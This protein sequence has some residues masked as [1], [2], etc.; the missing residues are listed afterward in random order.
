MMSD[1]KPGTWA[2]VKVE[3]TDSDKAFIKALISFGFED[4]EFRANAQL[5]VKLGVGV[6]RWFM[7]RRYQIKKL[8]AVLSENKGEKQ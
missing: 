4:G 8:L 3:E 1:Q 5:F 2:N 6:Q 7:N